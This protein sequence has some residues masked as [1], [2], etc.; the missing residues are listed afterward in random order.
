MHVDQDNIHV[1]PNGQ[2]FKRTSDPSI[3]QY[4]RTKQTLFG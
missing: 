1:H 3:V 2:D 4:N